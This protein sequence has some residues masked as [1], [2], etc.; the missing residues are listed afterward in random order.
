M[1]PLDL[2][3]LLRML[4]FL[5]EDELLAMCAVYQ[6][7]DAEARDAAR[8]AASAAAHRQGLFD[9]M[10]NLQGSIIQW[11]GSDIPPSAVFTF[12]PLQPRRLL[13]DLRRQAVPSLLDAATALLLN[14]A[15]SDA[16]RATLLV[17]IEAASG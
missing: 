4:P 2:Q 6:G 9:E 14:D 5:E 3:E 13:G 7:A 1:K 17:P 16:D 15:I 11:A 8:A 10:G 12:A